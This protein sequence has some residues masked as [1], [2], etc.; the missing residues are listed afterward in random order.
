[1][2]GPFLLVL[3]LLGCGACSSTS[4]TEPPSAP[5]TLWAGG[6]FACLERGGQF[7]CRL[8]DYLT[9]DHGQ[10]ELPDETLSYVSIR[11]FGGCAVAADG[12]GSCFGGNANHTN[13]MPGGTWTMI[14]H[15]GAQVC[16]LRSDGTPECWGNGAAVEA[17]PPGPFVAV[18]A[19]DGA[20][21]AREASGEITCWGSDYDGNITSPPGTWSSFILPNS[22]LCMLDAAGS[23]RCSGLESVAG[24]TIPTGSGHR[25]LTGGFRFACALDTDDKAVCWGE[26]TVGQLDAPEDRFLEIASADYLTCGLKADGEVKCWGCRDESS[27]EPSLYCNWDAP[28][29][30]WV[31]G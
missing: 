3:T 29:P 22:Y 19:M 30:W 18:R 13:D 7:D 16:G 4:D 27:S 1:M 31:P 26:N 2:V 6:G 8:L 25:S 17:P 5:G 14:E 11:T 21:C 23:I 24:A 28:A 20:A 12:T 9:S 10:A 15:G